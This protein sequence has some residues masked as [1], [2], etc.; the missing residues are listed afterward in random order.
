MNIDG[1]IHWIQYFRKMSNNKGKFY[2]AKGFIRA[3]MEKKD[4]LSQFF[5]S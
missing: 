2:Y 1:C 3:K 5:R 4:K